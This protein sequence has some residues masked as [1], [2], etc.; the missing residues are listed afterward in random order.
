MENAFTLI[1]ARFFSLLFFSAE[2]LYSSHNRQN[3][4][5]NII[6]PYGNIQ[7]LRKQIIILNLLKIFSV[8]RDCNEKNDTGPKICL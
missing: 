5:E 2:T 8:Y 6:C 3:N 1:Y 4:V 7:I